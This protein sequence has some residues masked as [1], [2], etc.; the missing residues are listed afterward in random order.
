MSREAIGRGRTSAGAAGRGAH[1]G[2]RPT[3]ARRGGAFFPGRGVLPALA[4][5]P[6]PKAGLAPGARRQPLG[7]R[8]ADRRS[9]GLNIDPVGA[10]ERTLRLRPDYIGLNVLVGAPSGPML[11]LFVLLPYEISCPPLAA[12]MPVPLRVMVLSLSSMVA[13]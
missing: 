11:L 10:A 13:P 6:G 2:G 7:R 5:P 9:H 8:R 3:G 12:V 1:G 4:L